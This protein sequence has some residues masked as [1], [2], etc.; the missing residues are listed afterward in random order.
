VYTIDVIE[1]SNTDKNPSYMLEGV[2]FKVMPALGFGS[3]E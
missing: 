2:A 3:Q 1:K